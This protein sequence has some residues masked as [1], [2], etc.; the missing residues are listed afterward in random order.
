MTKQQSDKTKKKLENGTI[1]ITF[2]S[3]STI[4]IFKKDLVKR[5][6]DDLWKKCLWY[7]DPSVLLGDTPEKRMCVCLWV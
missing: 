6:E 1:L 3:S 2:I 7:M 5:G 4:I